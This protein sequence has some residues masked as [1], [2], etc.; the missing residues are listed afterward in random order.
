M[1]LSVL[2]QRET[3]TE[4]HTNFTFVLEIFLAADDRALTNLVNARTR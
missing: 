4:D 2:F 1:S 3:S